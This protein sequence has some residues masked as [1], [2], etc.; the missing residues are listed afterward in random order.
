MKDSHFL[1]SGDDLSNRLEGVGESNSCELELIWDQEW[2]VHV[3][4]V[5]TTR[6]KERVTPKQYQMF[7]L[8]ALK[9]LPVKEVAERVG[10]TVAAVCMARHR[11][12]RLLKQELRTLRDGLV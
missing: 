8:N 4:E 2:N 1:P 10:S 3:L 7:Y 11:V 9:E 12:G 5:A 6:V